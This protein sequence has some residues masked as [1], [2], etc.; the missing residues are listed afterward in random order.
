MEMS[1]AYNLYAHA[2]NGKWVDDLHLTTHIGL[3][4]MHHFDTALYS[5]NREIFF[6]HL[7]ALRPKLSLARMP[8]ASLSPWRRM[9]KMGTQSY[10]THCTMARTSTRGGT[11]EVEI[12]VE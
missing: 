6:R 7:P 8:Y 11:Y 10:L 12:F 9:V 5:R 2:K 1:L 3:E 4:V